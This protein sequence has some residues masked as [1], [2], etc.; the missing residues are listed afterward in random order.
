MVILILVDEVY[1]WVILCRQDGDSAL[2]TAVTNFQTEMIK[3]LLNAGADANFKSEV[4]GHWGS[5][6][7]EF[8]FLDG[9][10]VCWCWCVKYVSDISFLLQKGFE[11][12]TVAVTTNCVDI[13]DMLLK[14]G[15][16]INF[17]NLVIAFSSVLSCIVF[18]GVFFLVGLA[19]SVFHSLFVG[20][21]ENCC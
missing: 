2:L 8:A 4:C 5:F 11:A 20:T 21:G 6:S 15:A 12:L 10:F 9:L 17:N 13:V 14:A 3:L 18:W 16:D 19:C 1:S 7:S